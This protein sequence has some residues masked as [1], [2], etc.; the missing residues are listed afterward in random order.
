MR[1]AVV[2][3]YCVTAYVGHSL[4]SPD[5]SGHLVEVRSRIAMTRFFDAHS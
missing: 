4:H 3:M 1:G 5:P 2:G